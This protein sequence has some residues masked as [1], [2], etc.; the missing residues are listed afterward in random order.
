MLR[1]LENIL[2][3]SANVEETHMLEAT[4]ALLAYQFLRRAYG[5]HRKYFELV[6]RFERY[7]ADLMEAT[8][9][10]LV[11]NEDKGYV[12]AVPLG[13]VNRMR[14]DEVLLLLALRAMYDQEMQ[15]FQ[16]DDNAEAQIPLED[17]EMRYF[18]FTQRALPKNQTSFDELMR[19]FSRLGIAEQVVEDDAK[20]IRIFPTVNELLDGD[21]LSG[22]E[23]Y[24]QADGVMLADEEAPEDEL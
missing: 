21:A 1:E 8:N 7:F 4:Q 19:M 10:R 5:K 13:Y 16:V 23:D 20:A 12:G 15:R 17:F 2:N 3:G 9:H 6:V 14:L 11:V 22:I 24:L 18:K